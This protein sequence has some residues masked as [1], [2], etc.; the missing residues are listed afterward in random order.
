MPR[1]ESATAPRISHCYF[2][3]TPL[4]RLRHY[5]AEGAAAAVTLRY[6]A[7]IL[8]RYDAITPLLL[9]L[10]H[11]RRRHGYWRPALPFA[12]W[13]F[14]ARRLAATLRDDED[15]HTPLLEITP[16]A[17][18][19]TSFSAELSLRDIAAEPH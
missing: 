11:I 16:P 13:L 17:T 4:R 15:T 10:L 9:L 5:A 12:H 6:A 8:I 1:L 18:K 2:S 14:S 19:V 7:T 3:N